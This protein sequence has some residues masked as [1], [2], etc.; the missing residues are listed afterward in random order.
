MKRTYHLCWSGGDEVLFRTREDYIHGIICM[1]IAAYEK[2][3]TLVAYCLMSNHVHICVRG[4][5]I[6]AFIKAFRYSYSRYFNSKCHRRGR[7]GEKFFFLQE[8][9]GLHHLLTVIAYILRNPLHHGVCKTPFE[10]EFSSVHA[11]FGKEL[12]HHL[13]RIE[14]GGKIPYCQ[15]PSRHKLPQHVKIDQNGYLLTES[16]VDT[17]DLEHQFSTARSYLYFM[18]R[19]SG[20]AWEKEQL[21]DNNGNPPIMITDIERGV[22][23]AS[24]QHLLANETGRNRVQNVDDIKLCTIIDEHINKLYKGETVY[25]LHISKSIK[26]A[27][28]LRARYNLSKEQIGR[29]MAL[30]SPTLQSF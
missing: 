22:R 4:S 28:S 1:C 11:P 15:I 20:E 3:C 8:V 26:I 16:I 5:N 25:T 29:C 18:N 13:R 21:Q 12:G 2:G 19:L 24:T 10:Y 14:Q 9:N 30:S 23:C 27:E 17:A 7:L 6:K